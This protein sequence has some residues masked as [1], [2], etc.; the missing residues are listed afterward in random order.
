MV[1]APWLIDFQ[2]AHPGIVLD[3]AFENR[4][5]DLLRDEVDIAVRV[6]SEPPEHLVAR[7]LGELRYVA[8]ATP[9]HFRAQGLPQR[10]EDLSHRPV[11]TSGVVGRQLR[12]AATLHGE[13]H[14]VPLQPRL[15]TENFAYL[16]EAILAGLGVGIVPDYVVADAVADGRLQTA[17]HDWKLSIFGT[18]MF[19]LYMPNRHHTRAASALI[20][21]VLARARGI[22]AAG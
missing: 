20:D 16:R 17:L 21:F 15:M 6:I 18:R 4:V 3:V 7:D 19:M 2:R 11:L 10:L 5:V 14:E 1:M 9:E 8:C 22:K 13:R 12:L